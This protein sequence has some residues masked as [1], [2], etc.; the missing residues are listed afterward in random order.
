MMKATGWQQHSVRGF[1]AG[2]VR[3]KLKLNLDSKKI[4]GSRFYRIKGA[5]IK[6]TG[7]SSKRQAA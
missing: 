1:L 2:I 3:K 4:D 7:R 6:A 5:G